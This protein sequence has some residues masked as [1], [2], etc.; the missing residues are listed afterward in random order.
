MGIS[1]ASNFKLFLNETAGSIHTQRCGRLDGTSA[2][3][4]ITML[5]KLR[6]KIEPYNREPN[7]FRMDIN[8][9]SFIQLEF[10]VNKKKFKFIIDTVF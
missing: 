3:E 7:H 9:Y 2:Q 8:A 4:L 10:I 1:T 6:S 5:Q